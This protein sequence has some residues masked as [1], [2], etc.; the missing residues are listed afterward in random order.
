MTHHFR[1]K[2][3]HVIPWRLRK[4]E[5]KVL[6]IFLLENSMPIENWMAVSGG[7]E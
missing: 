1:R 6:K 7:R 3:A 2:L 5:T 4:C